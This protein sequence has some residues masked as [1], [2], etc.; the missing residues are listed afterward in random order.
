MLFAHEYSRLCCLAEQDGKRRRRKERQLEKRTTC[1]SA[2][3]FLKH[4]FTPVVNREVGLLGQAKQVQQ[5]FFQS[6]ANLAEFYQLDISCTDNL[7]YPLNIQ[8][9]F[10]KAKKAFDKKPT[11]LHLIIAKDKRRK[12]CVS[13]VKPYD[14]GQCLFYL[15]V[16]P[17]VSLMHS[18]RT[19]RQADLLLS[20]FAYLYQ[21]GG[22]PYFTQGFLESEYDMIYEW[23]TTDDTDYDEQESIVIMQAFKLMKYHGKKLFKSISH[24]YHLQQFESRV[25]QFKPTC[26]KEIAIHEVGQQLLA[27]YKQYPKRSIIDCIHECTMERQDDEKITPDQY[28]SFMWDAEGF[29][30]DQLIETVN[31]RFQEMV[32]IDEPAAVQYFDKL[33]EKEQHDL[34]FEEQF[35]DCLHNLSDLLNEL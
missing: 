32:D 1:A 27:V 4:S 14:T 7:Y 30:Y 15:P 21:V 22:V 9:A 5:E 17:V 19:K 12:A 13:T 3:G 29:I 10:E 11:G 28:I 23:Y 16:K 25:Q 33:P 31:V 6:L 34:G 20:M 26:K 2:N 24:R 18:R 35:F 8:D